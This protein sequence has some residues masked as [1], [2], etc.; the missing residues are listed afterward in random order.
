M[1]LIQRYYLNNKAEKFESKRIE[2]LDVAIII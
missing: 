2:I 1:L